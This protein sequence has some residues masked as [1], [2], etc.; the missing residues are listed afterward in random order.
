M[1]AVVWTLSLSEGCLSE[2]MATLAFP[3]VHSDWAIF[4]QQ[5]LKQSTLLL[6][7]KTLKEPEMLY[8]GLVGMQKEQAQDFLFVCFYFL[9]ILGSL[10]PPL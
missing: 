10:L 7:T 6:K 8:K 5:L 2:D 1:A 9:N 3:D 4:R